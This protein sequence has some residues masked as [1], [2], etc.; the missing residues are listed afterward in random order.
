MIGLCFFF[1]IIIFILEILLIVYRNNIV[2]IKMNRI[3]PLAIPSIIYIYIYIHSFI[4][5]FNIYNVLDYF[6]NS[7]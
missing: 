1:L 7:D 6:K 4:I 5:F 3:F 2:I